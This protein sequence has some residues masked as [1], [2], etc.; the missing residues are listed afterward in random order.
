MTGKLVSTLDLENAGSS[1][2]ITDFSWTNGCPAR[3]TTCRGVPPPWA[4]AI[5]PGYFSPIRMDTTLSFLAGAMYAVI[6]VCAITSMAVVAVLLKTFEQLQ[7][8]VDDMDD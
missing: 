4:L 1:G 8:Q 2:F 7:D 3:R 5:R 6:G